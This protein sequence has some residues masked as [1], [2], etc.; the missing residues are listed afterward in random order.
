MHKKKLFIYYDYILS[1]SKGIIKDIR[2]DIKNMKSYLLNY[3][4]D[5]K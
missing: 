5:N 4:I 2:V 3:I 1:Y